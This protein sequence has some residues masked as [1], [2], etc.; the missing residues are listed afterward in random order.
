MGS[1][2]R[3]RRRFRG[4]YGFQNGRLVRRLLDRRERFL[5]FAER[6]R[7]NLR[8][9]IVMSEIVRRGD[10]DVGRRR[11]RWTALRLSDH[12]FDETA[13]F[14]G[15]LGSTG[16]PRG[17]AAGATHHTSRRPERIRVD[18]VGRGAAWAD[19]HH[20]DARNGLQPRYQ[21]SVNARETKKR[22][23][24]DGRMRLP[25]LATRQECAKSAIWTG[26]RA[27]DLGR[28]VWSDS[29]T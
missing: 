6:L 29:R 22:L 26:R 23:E 3:Q 24:M 5:T 13:N 4:W 14:G 17:L 28:R 19:D 18:H 2:R 8:R 7:R 15:C 10:V 12:V 16:K 25:A 21:R 20:A 27:A 1:R 11:R 9:R